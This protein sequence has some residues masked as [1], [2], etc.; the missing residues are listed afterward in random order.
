MVYLYFSGS[1]ALV[2]RRFFLKG[3]GE[4]GMKIWINTKMFL[5]GCNKIENGPFI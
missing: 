2:L 1:L 4:K 3:M 5:S